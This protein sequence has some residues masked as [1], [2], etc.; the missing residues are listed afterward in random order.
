MEI[1]RIKTAVEFLNDGQSFK[2]GDLRLGMNG[3]NDMY[4]TGWSQ[5]LNLENLTRSQ[6]LKELDEIKSLFKQMLD[7]SQEL[8]AFIQDKKIKYN[9]AFNYGMG[10]IDTCSE[11]DGVVEWG[12]EVK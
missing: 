6:A 10:A 7:V 4:V 5:Y 8:K 2:V 1:G 9:L 3:K 11:K 12:M